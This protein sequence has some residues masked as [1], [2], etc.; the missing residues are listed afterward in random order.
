MTHEDYLCGDMTWLCFYGNCEGCH[1]RSVCDQP[2]SYYDGHE[3]EVID[4]TCT[5]F[6]YCIEELK[7]HMERKGYKKLDDFRGK[8]TNTWLKDVL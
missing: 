1:L 4:A 3:E 8:V 2:C 6:R 5:M 7:V